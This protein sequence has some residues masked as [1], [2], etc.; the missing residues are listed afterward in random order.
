MPSPRTNITEIT[1]GLATLGYQS[2]DRALEVRPRHISHVDDLVFDNLEAARASGNFDEEFN[3][4]WSNGWTFARSDQGLRGRPPWHLEWKG[5]HKPASRSIETIPADLR[6]DHVYLISCKYGSEILHNSSPVVLFD[7]CLAPTTERASQVDWYETVA[8]EPYRQLWEPILNQSLTR[9]PRSPLEASKDQRNSIKAYLKANPVDTKSP[10]YCAFV[11][12][13]SNQTARRWQQSIG[14]LAGQREMIWRLLRLQGAP[15]YLL[16]ADKQS[17]PLRYRVETP[18]D[19]NQRY[20]V[21]GLNITAGNRGQPAVNW[22]ASITSNESAVEHLVEGFVEIR[23]SHGKLNGPPEA[24]VHLSTNPHR[25]PGYQP[26][27]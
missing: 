23:W 8:P 12:D 20:V 26:I 25:V 24:K 5:P 18:W 11:D 22:T 7:R 1:T 4:A 27:E 15:Y 19:F 16:G 9:P 6:I 2:L 13:V 10:A 14:N 3:I 21:N 17:K